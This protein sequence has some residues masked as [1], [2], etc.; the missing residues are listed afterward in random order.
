MGQMFD[1]TRNQMNNWRCDNPCTF[2]NQDD[3]S[4]QQTPCLGRVKGTGEL[5]SWDRSDDLRAKI[6]PPSCWQYKP[7]DI[8]ALIA[9]NWNERIDKD[10]DQEYWVDPRALSSGRSCPSD[11]NNND[12]S[13]G[14]EDMQAGGKGTRKGQGTNDQKRKRQ[15]KGI[16]KGRATDEANAKG[17]RNTDGKGIVKQ[18]PGDDNIC[19]AV[20]WQLQKEMNEADADTE[21]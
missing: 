12:N 9:L 19:Y 17:N 8:L 7:G 4:N 10:D 3:Y 13:E 18:T 5:F 15:G 2:G 6:N 20:D 11:G 1:K 21:E 14:E 16:R